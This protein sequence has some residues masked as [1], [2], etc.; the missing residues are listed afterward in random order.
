[1]QNDAVWHA[2]RLGYVTASRFKDVIAPAKK[3]S[4][5]LAVGFS[6]AAEA[7]AWQLLG[8]MITKLPVISS[9]YA[10]DWGHAYEDQ[11]RQ[12]YQT[13]YKCEVELA[14]F[15]EHATEPFVGGSPDGLLAF[16]GILEIKC[17]Y[18][19]AVHLQTVD[20]GKVPAEHMPQIQGNLWVTGRSNCDFVSYDPRCEHKALFI[21]TVDRDDEYI[22]QLAERVTAFRDL[23]CGKF[24]EL[25]GQDTYT[26]EA[27]DV[28]RIEAYIQAKPWQRTAMFLKGELV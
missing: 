9:G 27:E 6:V 1:M 21:K 23:V 22:G 8:E 11:A 2:E 14:E 24:Y 17:P 25:T 12:E 15:T 10:L 20:S 18:T 3:N 4:N 19:T 5:K 13:R 16:D 26:L 28:A 7:Y